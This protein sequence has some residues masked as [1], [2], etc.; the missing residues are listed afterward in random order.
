MQSMQKAQCLTQGKGVYIFRCINLGFQWKRTL[1]ERDVLSL[2][3]NRK[4]WKKLSIQ[5]S[6][7]RRAM[8]GRGSHTHTPTAAS[9]SDIQSSFF[10]RGKVRS[11]DCPDKLLQLPLHLHLQVCFASNTNGNRQTDMTISAV[12]ELVFHT[13]ARVSDGVSYVWPGV[14]AELILP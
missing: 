8:S 9:S 14:R 10:Q 12:V 2:R 7:A 3:S 6:E 1:D 11:Q 5:A 13:L 4:V